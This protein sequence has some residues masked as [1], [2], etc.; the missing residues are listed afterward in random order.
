MFILFLVLILLVDSFYIPAL[1]L[2]TPVSSKFIPASV[3]SHLVTTSSFAL[4]YCQIAGLPIRCV[5]LTA[6]LH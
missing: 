6:R 2:P 5:L 4:R 3:S 1:V